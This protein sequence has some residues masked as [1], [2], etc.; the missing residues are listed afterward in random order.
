ML[1]VVLRFC[2]VSIIYVGNGVAPSLVMDSDL[3]LTTC[4]LSGIQFIVRN[5]A[6]LIFQIKQIII[7][8]YLTPPLLLKVVHQVALLEQLEVG[9]SD[10]ILEVKK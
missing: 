10:L 8:L 4:G 3:N 9:A 5:N 6:S 1:V 7:F 2:R